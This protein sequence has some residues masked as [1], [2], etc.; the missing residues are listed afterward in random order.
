MKPLQKYFLLAAILFCSHS[1]LMAQR[2]AAVAID[3]S[4]VNIDNLVM[5]DSAA[6]NRLFYS[7]SFT[8]NI[9]DGV[10]LQKILNSLQVAHIKNTTVGLSIIYSGGINPS[11]T[12]RK[13]SAATVMQMTASKLEAAGRSAFKMEVKIRSAQLTE[14]ANVNIKSSPAARTLLAYNFRIEIPGIATDR[15]AVVS[16]LELRT[17]PL[18]SF[19]I[20]MADIASWQQWIGSPGKKINGSIFM[21]APNMRDRIKVFQ[22]VSMELVS[23]TQTINPNEERAQRFTALVRPAMLVLD[24]V[25]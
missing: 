14:I 2:T 17:N 20:S 11:A 7:A 13:Y 18:I 10:D 23:I 3:G 1:L 25:K 16:G 4:T 8:F 19:E 24:E 6:G 22:L 15:I 9:T 12:E 21:L 5:Q